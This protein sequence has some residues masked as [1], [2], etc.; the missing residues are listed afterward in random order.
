MFFPYGVVEGEPTFPLTNYFPD[1]VGEALKRYNPLDMQQGAMANAQTHIVQLPNTYA[2]SHFIKGGT[3][4]NLDMPGFADGLIPGLGT[5]IADSW[6]SMY[7]GDTAYMRELAA[8]V[9]ALTS[10]T[11]SLVE[12]LQKLLAK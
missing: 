7:A 9:D 3:M 5:L 11:L 6:K 1:W 4:D 2:Y 12:F 10:V 8:K